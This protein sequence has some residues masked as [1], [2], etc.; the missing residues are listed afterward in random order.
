MNNKSSIIIAAT[1]VAS[2]ALASCT[3]EI[4]DNPEVKGK[5]DGLISFTL[6]AGGMTSRG[7]LFPESEDYPDNSIHH[8]DWSTRLD[9][10]FDRVNI[11]WDNPRRGDSRIYRDDFVDYDD[12]DGPTRY[13]HIWS[14][15][16][17]DEY[18][19]AQKQLTAKNKKVAST[20]KNLGYLK[21]EGVS[22]GRW[23]DAEIMVLREQ[24]PDYCLK[25]SRADRSSSSRSMLIT[26]SNLKRYWSRVAVHSIC[27]KEQ[28]YD[29]DFRLQYLQLQPLLLNP[30]TGRWNTEDD[31]YWTMDETQM[32]R[33]FAFAPYSAYEK[34]YLDW[35]QPEEPG[36]P[37]FRFD[38]PQ[39]VDDQIDLG[40]SVIDVAGHWNDAVPLTMDHA[41]CGIRFLV[42]DPAMVGTIKSIKVKG[43]YGAATL[44]YTDSPDILGQPYLGSDRKPEF[45]IGG[46]SYPLAADSAYD[47]EYELDYDHLYHDPEM[48]QFLDH[49]T[50]INCD[51]PSHAGNRYYR[52]T[53]DNNILLLMPQILR[54]EEGK[55]LARIEITFLEE[56]R[57]K[58]MTAYL[59]GVTEIDGEEVRNSWQP[60][61][62]YNYVIT[63]E[64][65]VY[66]LKLNDE[67]GMYPQVGGED[68]DMV[69]SYA[70][71]INRTTH[72]PTRIESLRWKPI[73][74]DEHGNRLTTID[75]NGN[76]IHDPSVA[77]AQA[78]FNM[79]DF[80]FQYKWKPAQVQGVNTDIWEANYEKNLTCGH[81]VV[82]AQSAL[83]GPHTDNLRAAPVYGTF[84]E[85][86]FLDKRTGQ[87]P[88][89][90]ANCY[91]INA[92]GYYRLPLVYGNAYREGR[93]QSSTCFDGLKDFNGRA[94]T[95]PNITDIER[96]T[97]IQQDVEHLVQIVGFGRTGLFDELIVYID[98][99][100][101][102]PGNATIGVTSIDESG[103]ESIKWSWHLWITDYNPY[104]TN[105][106]FRMDTNT[107]G[108]SFDFMK[109]NLGYIHPEGAFRSPRRAVYWRPAQP[110]AYI[111]PDTK[112]AKWKYVET[113]NAYLIMQEGMYGSPGGFAPYYYWGRKDPMLN[114]IDNV[115]AAGAYDLGVDPGIMRRLYS[116]SLLTS[117]GVALDQYNSSYTQHQLSLRESIRMPWIMVPTYS[118][119]DMGAGVFTSWWT[120]DDADGWGVS[121][122][123][124]G[125]NGSGPMNRQSYTMYGNLWCS[126]GPIPTTSGTTPLTKQTAIKTIYD[127]CPPGFMVP[128]NCAFDN[129][130]LEHTPRY[131]INHDN[132]GTLDY[133]NYM[134]ALY[135]PGTELGLSM[136]YTFFNSD[137]YKYSMPDHEHFL[138]IP[139]MTWLPV[140]NSAATVYVPSMDRTMQVEC[141][142]PLGANKSWLNTNI[143]LWTADVAAENVS[144]G[145][146]KWGSYFQV[147]GDFT[148]VDGISTSQM[149][150][151]HSAKTPRWSSNL[152]QIRP[153]RENF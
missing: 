52:V 140:R 64:E 43:L 94:I 126:G 4:I 60:G 2:L 84:E 141:Y 19:E 133:H 58:V 138:H 55:P 14:P 30:S 53:S 106:T 45:P 102:V 7:G 54:F 59:G 16:S 81:V 79:D 72:E 123:G 61:Y 71:Y 22:D 101:I 48:D 103:H 89:T 120:K 35:Q 150:S 82:G 86:V 144:G 75:D 92:P 104:L 40:A 114:V 97:W 139:A 110:R 78:M 100:T 9:P 37:V 148:T 13:S 50:D 39:S 127:P 77:W 32:Q 134:A 147:T 1:A 87:T 88:W 119:A 129:V 6:K 62:I 31:Y 5:E 70:I 116:N 96:A 38:V 90:T 23:G 85:P 111:D 8:I 24:M 95:S 80:Y 122:S 131:W 28:W 26:E 143:S 11:D 33:F 93:L 113:N 41:L 36:T 99:A 137:G 51:N 74:Y 142:L 146:V 151:T 130:N 136:G 145:F 67:G 44:R 68:F 117:N 112:G 153:V 132:K 124:S 27:Y 107:P 98:P 57:D 47:V 108:E 42:D 12:N 128:P 91:I 149:Y 121:L 118:G 135:A 69:T 76:F 17:D 18:V 3:D 10:Y 73:F 25:D 20:Y 66:V 115:N 63:S 125:Y 49:D 109:L 34:E 105:G 152:R 46:Y 83:S 15:L 21:T 65:I 29:T 56:G